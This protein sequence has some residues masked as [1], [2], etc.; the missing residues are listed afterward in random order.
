MKKLRKL[1]LEKIKKTLLKNVKFLDKQKKII[2]KNRSGFYLK[3]NFGN[4]IFSKKNKIWVAP[5]KKG[6]FKDI[7]KGNRIVF[8]DL[9]NKEKGLKNYILDITKKTKTIIFLVDNHN[10]VLELWQK[11]KNLKL[12]HFDLHPD[13]NQDYLKLNNIF[14][15][16]NI[17]NYINYAKEKGFIKKNHLSFT[18][19]FDF[20]KDIKILKKEKYLINLDLDLFVEEN[21]FIDEEQV[22]KTIIKFLPYTELIT[23]AISPLFIEQKYALKLAK[24]FFKFL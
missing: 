22:I 2:K 13:L 23:I 4:N 12:V 7:K 9:E 20:K 21:D 16:T 18:Q 6:S 15:A 17:A 1:R 19:S 10:Y 11:F 8:R 3:G 5:I 14:K 24:L